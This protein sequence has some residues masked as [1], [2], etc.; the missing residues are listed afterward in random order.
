[1]PVL[2]FKPGRIEEVI[3][4]SLN[5]SLRIIESLKIEV[6]LHDYVEL[7]VEVDRPDM[8]SLEGIARQARGVMGL[9]EGLPSYELLDTPYE[10]KVS[11]VATRPYI[12][13]AIVWDVNVD[14]DYL[15]E[16]IQFQE[17]LHISIG[18][19]RS[20]VA[21]GLHDL[22]K[23]PSTHLTYAFED[24]DNVVFTPLGYEK[25]MSLREVFSITEQ[26]RKYGGISRSGN[27]HPVLRAGGEVISVP[28]VINAELTRIEPGTRHVFIDVTG[29]ELKPVLD[30]LSILV[31][32]LAERGKGRIGRVTVKTSYGIMREPTLNHTTRRLRLSYVERVLGIRLDPFTAIHHLRRMRY[33]ARPLDEEIIEVL[34]PRYRIDVMHPIDLVE[35]IMLSI[36][37]HNLK[38]KRPR[39]LLRG[40]LKPSYYWGREARRILAYMGFVELMGYTLVPCSYIEFSPGAQKPIKLANPVG[41]E[42]ACIRSSL[43]PLLLRAASRNQHYVP[44]KVFE[45]GEAYVRDESSDVK[46]S[47]RKRIAMLIMNH[48]V[49]YEDIQAYTYKLLA[50]L[51]D[52]V[53]EVKRFSHRIFIEG[54]AAHI[55]TQNKV[56]I[57]LGEVHP[58]VLEEFGITYPTAIAEID[59]TS[60]D[61]LV[62]ETKP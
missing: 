15:E 4:A 12:A 31:A 19:G 5:E 29:P 20:R 48:R 60:L 25:K 33:D 61:T 49:G 57:V 54:R 47:A 37:L 23:L 42:S 52:Q 55:R 7:E 11:H 22:E 53:V 46:V 50:A 51:G 10:I 56:E 41:P 39:R 45:S 43:V 6:E 27:K 24:I 16:L 1:M 9:E 44:L 21:I 30:T 14:E 32:N 40:R 58:Q 2:K 3:G 13:S 17:K 35:D 26:G 18:S 59:Y 34:V 8:Y 38:P 36:G 28:P 62:G